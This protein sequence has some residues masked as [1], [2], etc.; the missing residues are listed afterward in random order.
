[1]GKSKN[2]RE[3]LIKKYAALA[4]KLGSYPT[5]NDLLSIGISRDTMRSFFGNLDN[6]KNVAKTLFPEQFD[7][8]QDPV[9]AREMHLER[10]AEIVKDG[11]RL[12]SL[13]DLKEYNISSKSLCFHFG[14]LENLRKEAKHKYPHLFAGCI[15]ESEYSSDEY[16]K[17][18]LKRISKYN[19]FIITSAVNGHDL[20]IEAYKSLKTLAKSQKALLL[21][22]PCEDRTII[23]AKYKGWFFDP[24]LKDE[25]FV[26]NETP[27]NDNILISS[28]RVNVNQVDPHT[29]IG[30][31][32]HKQGSFIFGSPK[33]NLQFFPTSNKDFP[34]A[35]MSTGVITKPKY[36]ASNRRQY[37]SN[38]DH[39]VGAIFL[40]KDGKNL[41]HFT[42]LQSDSNGNIAH[43]GRLYT[44]KGSKPYA[45]EA[46]VMGDLHAGHHDE[47]ALKC[48][49]D[50]IKETK[51]KKVFLHDIFDGTSVSHHT[52]N[53]L[54]I[55]VLNAERGLD[56]LLS[57]LKITAGILN[58]MIDRKLK[59]FVVQSNHDDF[60]HR[61]IKRRG[62]MYDTKNYK[63][64]SELALDYLNGKDPLV[65]GLKKYGKL[66]KGVTFFTKD[67]DYLIS[68]IQLAA[69][70][71]LGANG[72]R[73]PSKAGIESAYGDAVVGHS[74]TAG[75]LRGVWQ[76]GTTSL[77]KLEYNKGSSSW[78]HTSC[79]VYPS[80]QRQLI[81]SI[82]GKYKI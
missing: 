1:M 24:I 81:N 14:N 10:Y 26:F 54:V 44:P 73:N 4:K 40:Q 16:Q 58:K 22:I 56:S 65:S 23:K 67:D 70:G 33:Q 60:L 9:P 57:E 71:D 37:L 36:Q 64:A 25:I 6:F 34:R 20:D 17:N 75:I 12:P 3:G 11:I 63:I 29:G 80:G 77:L 53:D 66:K 59:L 41:Y 79:L 49:L 45:P 21:I 46:F 55:R 48:W 28:I 61:Y 69:H 50:V 82:N 8:V 42:Q 31:L 43:L 2:T 32:T 52:E 15:E 5:R 74:H 78:T 39:T 76:V 51:V 47:T 62:F 72:K 27:I 18:I 35:S 13:S 68:D 19:K 7:K 30:R 38:K